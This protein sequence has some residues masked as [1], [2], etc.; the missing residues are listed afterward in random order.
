MAE[1]GVL[2]LSQKE[3][4]RLHI[5]H[6]ALAREI[7]QREAAE[8][9]SLSY[10]QIKRIVKR[11]KL[12][13]DAGIAHKSRGRLSN[14]GLPG[15]IRDKAIA[16]CRERYNDFGPTLASEKLAQLHGIRVS[17]ETL[18]SWLIRSGDWKGKRKSRKH[19]QWRERK[20]YFGELVQV[21]GSHHD[22]FEGRG[23]ETVFMGYIDDAT[24]KAFGRF[25][26]HEGTMPAM[27]SFKR[28]IRKYGI[29]ASVYVDKH[30]TYKSTAK[31][32]IEENLSNREPLSEFERALEEL[33]VR[34]IHANSPQAKGRVE[35]LFGTLQ[36]RLV[37][38]MRLRNISSAEEA[39]EFLE[40]YLPE[41]NKRFA[42][43]PK[44]RED[45]HRRAP[46]GINLDRV[47]CIKS[48]RTLK[49]DFTISYENKIYQIEESIR[50][51]RVVVEERINGAIRIGY[52]GKT[53][54]FKEIAA[55]P[56]A[57]K[58]AKGFSVRKNWRPPHDHPWRKWKL[59]RRTA[60]AARLSPL[61]SQQERA[62]E[63]SQSMKV[64][65]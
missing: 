22:W 34:V 65:V 64:G 41:H 36:D 29:P 33:G 58:K 59:R 51:K 16:L 43:A 44:E 54:R 20:H 14:R 10:R 37:K 48:E 26:G 9:L 60:L 38:E 30:S 39:N 40:E 11:V 56:T 31:P 2:I 13:G 23:E 8:I 35:R 21:D 15:E 19:R 53:L 42:V 4:N 18:R 45:L 1:K 61:G 47:L 7:T 62:V 28:Y 32:S 52:K 63:M 5:V 49:N 12:K 6:K 3:L 55:R 46:A 27:D 17:V 24:G 25:Y 57:A 50:G